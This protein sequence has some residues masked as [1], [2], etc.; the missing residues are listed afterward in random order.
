ME[1]YITVEGFKQASK[2]YGLRHTQLIAD[3]D[4]SVYATFR[5]GEL[6]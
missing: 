6:G 1:S 4:S 3:G 2:D 5:E